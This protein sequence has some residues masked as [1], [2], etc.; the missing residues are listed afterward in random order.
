M[1]MSSLL[2]N[3]IPVTRQLWL[4]I[5]TNPMTCCCILIYQFVSCA[6]NEDTHSIISQNGFDVICL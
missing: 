1:V 4:N 6:E 3:V 2:L 5:L